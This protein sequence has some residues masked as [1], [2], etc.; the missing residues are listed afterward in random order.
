M[1]P[2]GDFIQSNDAA[3]RFFSQFVPIEKMLRF[4]NVYELFFSEDG[5]KPFIRNW[6]QLAPHMLAFIK[7]EVFEL[8]P[9]NDAYRLYNRLLKSSDL[10]RNWQHELAAEDQTPLFQME[11]MLGERNLA[12]FSTYTTMGSPHDVT[13]QELRLECFFPADE[14]TEAF[15]SE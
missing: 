3:V 1:S 4:T 2:V 5:F 6:G 11:L 9:G 12:L 13:L 14:S 15:F 7:Q 10:E 8:E